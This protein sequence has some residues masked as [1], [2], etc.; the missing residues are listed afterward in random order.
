M[1]LSQLSNRRE[2]SKR[3]KKIVTYESRKEKIN[4]EKNFENYTNIRIN[5]SETPYWNKK[6]YYEI[7]KCIMNYENFNLIKKNF[8]EV[9]AHS[10]STPTLNEIKLEYP[11][12]MQKKKKNL[13]KMNEKS[14]FKKN[15][16]KNV[17]KRRNLQNEKRTY[18]INKYKE[19]KKK[20]CIKSGDISSNNKYEDYCNNP[21]YK[22]HGEYHD[23][24]NYD[25]IKNDSKTTIFEEN[26]K[27]KVYTCDIHLL[28]NNFCQFFNCNSNQESIN[29]ETLKSE[30]TIDSNNS[31]TN[32]LFCKNEL[33]LEWGHINSPGNSTDVSKKDSIIC[34]NESD[35]NKC[36]EYKKKYINLENIKIN[37][38]TTENYENS[39]MDMPFAKTN[40]YDTINEMVTGDN[41]KNEG[42]FKKESISK[43]LRD[44]NSENEEKRNSNGNL[45]TYYDNISNL[46]MP[47]LLTKE[48]N[49]KINYLANIDKNVV[50]IQIQN[51]S[52]KIDEYIS[53]ERI[54]RAQKL[55]DH[56]KKYTEYYI[57]YFKKSNE[58]DVVEKLLKYYDENCMDKNIK[59][60]INNLKVNI[61][62]YFLNFFRLNEMSSILNHYCYYFSID[63]MNSMASDTVSDP[64]ENNNISKYYEDN[65]NPKT[66]Y[67]CA[68]SDLGIPWK[69]IKCFSLPGSGNV[70]K[71]NSNINNNNNNSHSNEN[72]NNNGNYSNENISNNSNENINFNNSSSNNNNNNNN[73]INNNGNYSNEN[74]NNNNNSNHSNENISNNS[75]ENININNSSSNNNNNNEN[76][77]N[78]INNNNNN[79]D[80][81]VIIDKIYHQ[82][83]ITSNII[84]SNTLENEQSIDHQNINI[85]NNNQR[86]MVKIIQK[87]SKRFKNFRKAKQNKEGWIKENEKYL[88]MW[89]RV[90][91]EN[92]IS[93]HV[94]AKLPYEVNRILSILNETELSINWAP[95]LTS[96]KKI[97]HL[98]RA[99]SII[100]QLY[101]YPI[102]GK[103]ESLMYCL[104]ANSLEELGCI[105][106]CCKAPPELDKDILFY[107]NICE[108]IK[109]N[110]YEEIIKVNDV[111]TKSQKSY[112][113]VTFFNYRLPDPIP[114][115]DRQKAADLCFL[116]YPLN[117]GNS[118]VLELFLHFE[119]E[120]KY[121]P[122]KMVT[123]FIKKIVKNM[124]ENIIKSCKNYEHIY[125]DFLKKNSEFYVW[126]DDQIKKFLK[127]KRNTKLID[128]ISLESYN[129]QENNE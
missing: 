109:I 12:N 120:F 55:I 17:R 92:N 53:D 95:F 82:Q 5:R 74:I 35:N 69:S 100:T 113:E 110:K 41:T 44:E 114:K 23:E 117:N 83:Y 108:K 91:N 51:F 126:L 66:L 103:K 25:Y 52:Q 4:K 128:S 71:I 122:I 49:N 45:T 99:S 33:Y 36:S 84:T 8:F 7:E 73:N 63:T 77:N 13:K 75:N 106:L 80:N 14:E 101:E 27:K 39:L 32:D 1:S 94:R 90:D 97:K 9:P 104:G 57:N 68:N 67:S 31:K 112:K 70:S 61:I 2:T 34:F 102:I 86:H 10:S 64:N 105:I 72:I 88:D 24:C 96:A 42:N 22:I 48:I 65:M 118:T 93:V 15:I 60:N 62:L 16:S 28:F 46:D 30:L 18:S 87:Y 81:K 119:N 50:F 127:S 129:D 47:S 59:Y 79:R 54:F 3:K 115:I 29:D 40:D 56:V 26:L 11:N 19:K 21:D 76:M 85:K 20:G 6:N 107:E 121:T 116:L 37:N 89:H 125:S 38:S 43:I 58:K 124:Y 78:S 123:Y 98:S 111:P